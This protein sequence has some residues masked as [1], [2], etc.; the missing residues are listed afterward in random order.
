V[1][2]LGGWSVGADPPLLELADVPPVSRRDDLAEWQSLADGGD[3]YAAG[4]VAR[5][6][7]DDP[8]GVEVT[9]WAGYR[10]VITPSQPTPPPPRPC[11]CRRIL[12]DTAHLGAPDWH[13]EHDWLDDGRVCCLER[14][15]WKGQL[16]WCRASQ[17]VPNE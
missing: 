3:T 15:A 5:M 7:R 13:L 11:E 8:D 10:R 17:W 14:A 9:S 12:V 4:R 6:Q 1:K 16:C 2:L